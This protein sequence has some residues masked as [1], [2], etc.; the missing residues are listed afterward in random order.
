MV[1]GITMYLY[2]GISAFLFFFFFFL[3]L[4]INHETPRVQ[5]HSGKARWA[6]N[7]YLNAFK[8]FNFY[9]TLVHRKTVDTYGII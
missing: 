6:T 9:A 5:V 1:P 7:C 2:N 3:Y 4:R 8:R